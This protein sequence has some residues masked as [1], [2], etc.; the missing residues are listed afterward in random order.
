MQVGNETEDS[1]IEGKK[2]SDCMSTTAV[3]SVEGIRLAKVA[4]FS[5]IN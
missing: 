2:F 3:G 4:T 1:K 5:S